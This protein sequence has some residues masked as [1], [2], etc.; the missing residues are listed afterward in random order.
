MIIKK[1][2]YM[3]GTIKVPFLLY[4]NW[5]DGIQLRIAPLGFART[6]GFKSK[7]KWVWDSVA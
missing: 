2:L 7:I 1:G 4:K 6:D 3:K 5:N